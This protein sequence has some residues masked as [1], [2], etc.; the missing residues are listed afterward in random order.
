M[1]T[2]A[3]FIG[4]ATLAL[5][6]QIAN[7]DGWTLDGTSSNLSFGS[8]KNETNGESH[9]FGGL[10]GTVSKD[11]AVAVSVDLTTVNTN[12]DIRNE[13]IME[14]VFK[15]AKTAEIS[16]QIDMAQVDKLA[17]GES[18]LID[19]EGAVSV[20]GTDVD[21]DAQMFVMRVSESKAMVATN[22]MVFLSMEDAEFTAGIDKLM[23]LASLD[24]IT[25]TSPVT[26][27]LMFDLKD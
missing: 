18:T 4:A 11:G 13:R 23:E 25:R 7:A 9:S 27:R 22:G 14:H 10:S 16:A 6:A 8:V 19:V 24:S 2:F 5:T 21:L 20:V 12:I 3:T 26:M 1:N 17:V 15:A